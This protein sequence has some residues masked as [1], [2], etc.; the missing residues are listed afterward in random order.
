MKLLVVSR[1]DKNVREISDLTFPIIKK[2]AKKWNADF[3]VLSKNVDC[4][5]DKHFYGK[6]H[7]RIL[8]FFDLLKDYDRILHLDCDVVIN[9][10]CPNIFDITPYDKI[11]TIF[12]DKEKR[13]LIRLRRIAQI[14]AEWG[15]IGWKENY[16]N[17]GVFL[18]SKPHAEIFKRFKGKLWVGWGYDDVHLGYQINRLG[19]KIHEL[20]YRFNH[21]CMFSERWNNNASRF[22]SYVIHYAGKARFPDKET[23]SRIELIKDDIKK[24]YDED[25]V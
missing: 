16:I 7:Y 2:F 24:I 3:M 12:E 10:N 19:M 20:D 4:P 8:E 1:A 18:V 13:Q 5:D 6:F 17:T 21:M 14:Q 15:D 23:R 11:G 22:D 25:Y 9:K